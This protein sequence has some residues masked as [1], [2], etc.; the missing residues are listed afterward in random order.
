MKSLHLRI[1]FFFSILLLI[2]GSLISYTQYHSSTRLVK[3]SLG[4]QARTLAESAVKLI[5]LK[6]YKEIKCD[7]GENAYYK[8][9]RA[10]LNDYRQANNLKYLYTMAVSANGAERE[11]YYV[12]DGAPADAS[13][14]DFSPLGKVE[15]DVSDK[16]PD[17]F[18]TQKAQIGELS[19][20]EAYGATITAYV[21]IMGEDG[22]LVGIMGADFDATRVYDLIKDNGQK[23]IWITAVLLLVSMAACYGFARYIVIPLRRITREMQRVQA[24]DMTVQV[25]VRGRDEIGRLA[26][27]FSQMVGDLRSMIGG[28]KGSTELLRDS[29]QTLAQNMETMERQG[30]RIIS[31]IEDA[32]AGADTQRKAAADTARA[33][34]EVGAGVQRIAESSSVVAEAS[35]V[36]TEAAREGDE[37]ILQT[38]RQMEAIH[39]SAQ[40]AAVHIGRLAERS[41]EVGQIVVA[42]RDIAAQTNLLALN[43]AIEAARAGEHGRGFAVVAEQV[44]KLASQS[45]MS[46]YQIT[47]LI[48]HMVADT[49]HAVETAQAESREV[50]TGLTVVHRTGDTFRRILQEVERV[51]DQV[52]DVS[53]VSEEIAAAS[54]EVTAAVDEIA[55]MSRLASDQASGINSAAQEQAA[56]TAVTLKSSEELEQMAERLE[57]LVERFKV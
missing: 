26:A 18:E 5:D 46:A 52:Q 57:K 44:R 48:E 6:R 47:E 54:Q 36:A 11:Y 37:N 42:I 31:H 7:G 56:S 27:G 38:V 25:T 17:A 22:K 45:E 3:E 4:E 15:K 50:E 30:E 29:A 49:R 32:A 23:S 28:I 51:A 43:A 39:A 41:D 34:E 16:L 24:G 9:L 8:E 20:Q 14:D 35:Q 13:G 33:M 19:K 21:P 12:V 55:R 40:T 53:A 10:K 1:L 2:N